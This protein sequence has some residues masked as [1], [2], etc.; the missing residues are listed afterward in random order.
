MRWSADDAHRRRAPR[1]APAAVAAESAPPETRTTPR[2]PSAN[3]AALPRARARAESASRPPWPILGTGIGAVRATD[4][5]QRP[6]GQAHGPRLKDARLSI[7]GGSVEHA[8]GARCRTC[9]ETKEDPQ[10]D[11]PRR[12]PGC[13]S[14]ARG[15]GGVRARTTDVQVTALSQGQM[16]SSISCLIN[17]ERSSHRAGAGSA[18][19]GGLRAGGAQP[20]DRDDQ[21]GLL[22]AHL[23]A[24]LTFIDRIQATGYMRGARSL[25]GRREPG[26]G[27]RPA[28]H[29]AVPGHRVDEQPAAPGEPAAA[30][31]PRDRGRGRGRDPLSRRRPDRRHRLERVRLPQ[32]RQDQEGQGEGQAQKRKAQNARARHLARR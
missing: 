19:N 18:A 27:D 22:R 31:L 9:V 32:L 20:L 23:P 6:K 28:E 2:V 26:L 24:G 5:S 4:F 16:E 7:A 3:Q 11:R 12:A 1:R 17:E 10:R 25:G 21:P 14:R 8:P 30:A 13:S 29:A 15:L